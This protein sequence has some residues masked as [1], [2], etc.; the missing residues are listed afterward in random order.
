MPG[1]SVR[2][3]TTAQP[4]RWVKETLPPRVWERWELMIARFSIMTFAGIARAE[5]AVGMESESSMFFAVRA[6]APFILESTSAA[7]EAPRPSA[8]RRA[9]RW[10]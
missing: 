1:I 6:G 8:A 2:A 4:M 5:V 7:S 9:T 10:A 3:S